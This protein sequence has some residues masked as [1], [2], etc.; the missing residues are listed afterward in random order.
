MDIEAA[1]RLYHV[2]D[3]EA[4]G[5]RNSRDDFK[6]EQSFA[7]DAANFFQIL[8]AGDAGDHRAENQQGDA[9]SYKANEGVAEGLHL[10]GAF[11]A[12]IAES[13]GDQH[14]DDDLKPEGGV[15]GFLL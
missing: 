14:G 3:D 15:E 4:D 8:H 13:D 2:A 9:H 11:R 10:D 7:A 1:A 6:I 5:Q 12:E